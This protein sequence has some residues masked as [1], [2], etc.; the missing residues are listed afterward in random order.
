MN[1]GNYDRGQ[2][3][4]GPRSQDPWDR[5]G[6][7]PEPSGF[8]TN[9]PYA[10]PDYVQ[11]GQR[12]I[13]TGWQAFGAAY[14]PQSAPGYN[15]AHPPRPR[16]G[17]GEAIRLYFK[18]YA[19]FH[20]RASRSE[21][22]WVF[23]AGAILTPILALPAV[24]LM[25]ASG[26]S[27]LTGNSAAGPGLGLMAYALFVMVISVGLFLPTLSLQ[28]RR[29]HDAGFSGFFI[30]FAYVP[31]LNYLTWT[32]PFVMSLFPS[33]PAGVK[34]DNPNGSQPAAR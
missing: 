27:S 9:D 11:A 31:Y 3:G 25:V 26:V 21:F 18:N 19:V 23:V 29:L 8:V 10:T 20:G 12:P 5:R 33:S 34:Y 22:W 14:G 24:F 30:V 32:V 1:W 2:P 15:L 4:L 7:S 6:G 16:V 17:F 28:V 13:T